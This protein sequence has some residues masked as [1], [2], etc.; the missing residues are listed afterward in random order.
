[1]QILQDPENIQKITVIKHVYNALHFQQ[2]NSFYL[3]FGFFIFSVISIRGLLILLNYYVQGRFVCN[4][5]TKMS[6]ETIKYYLNQRYPELINMHSGQICKNIIFEV[7]NAVS[8]VTQVLQMLMAFTTASSLLLLLLT[9]EPVVILSVGGIFISVLLF[10]SYYVSPIISRKAQVMERKRAGLHSLLVDVFG[11]IKDIKVYEASQYFINIFK[12]TV[13][14]INQITVT[15]SY[16]S[17]FPGVILNV[18]TFGLLIFIV[19][20]ILMV[21]GDLG[22]ALPTIA[23]IGLASQR[24]LPL[25]N[26]MYNSLGIVKQYEPAVGIS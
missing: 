26:Q 1:M 15:F 16:I 5:R 20:S 14:S 4:L 6:E 24:M 3:F 7:N 12:N 25:F 2:I 17:N 9:I 8:V 13:E 23:V 11:S 10:I 18:I 21:K 22:G 19:L